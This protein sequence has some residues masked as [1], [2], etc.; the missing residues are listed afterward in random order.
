MI[1][2]HGKPMDTSS[3]WQQ[4]LEANQKF[5]QECYEAAKRELERDSNSPIDFVLQ[6]R[7]ILQLAQQIKLKRNG[8]NNE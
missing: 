2:W 1:A 3:E 7:R 5:E 6:L 4:Q 8:E